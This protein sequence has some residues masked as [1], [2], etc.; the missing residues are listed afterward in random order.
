M[1]NIIQI[2]HGNDV[3]DGKLA[4]YELGYSDTEGKLY[5]GGPLVDGQFGNAKEISGSSGG[6]DAPGD[7]LIP[8][9]TIIKGRTYQIFDENGK[10][11][12]KVPVKK[13]DKVIKI[14]CSN[15]KPNTTYKLLLYTLQKNRGNASRYWRHPDDRITRT[16]GLINKGKITGYAN[17][18][19]A[20][21]QNRNNFPPVQDWMLR[22]DRLQDPNAD[23]YKGV[24]QTEWEFTTNENFYVFELNL[25]SWILPLLKPMDDYNDQDGQWTLMGIPTLHPSK[26]CRLFQFRIR[27]RDGQIGI[28]NNFM[29]ISNVIYD[30][31]TKICEINHL[32]IKT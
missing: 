15:L 4:P 3:P 12:E 1:S 25:N 20:E 26:Y 27:D 11:L 14:Y 24:L 7:I 6:S 9:T 5:I 13:T 28:A 32:S 8:T 19:G 2:K 21:R 29:A 10:P 18:A 23:L 31:P 30:V 22:K 16:G 17:I